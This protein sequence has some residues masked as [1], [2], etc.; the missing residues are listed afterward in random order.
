MLPP[1]FCLVPS[2]TGKT[3]YACGEAFS[4][5]LTLLSYAV[6]YLPYF[7]H[8]FILAG[9]RGMGKST[10]DVRGLFELEQI[11]FQEQ[12]LFCRETQKI[13]IPEGEEL[14]LPTWEGKKHGE[15]TLL[16]HLKTPCRFKAD[17][18]LSTDLSFP[19]LFNLIVRRIRTVWALEGIPVYFEDFPA[20]QSRADAIDT[21]ESS[22][23]WKDWTRYSSRQKASMQLGGLQGSVRYHGNLTAFLPF[24]ALAEKLHIGKQTSF[25]LGQISFEWKAHE[26]DTHS[27]VR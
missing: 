10:D 25:G 20:M 23:F 9:Q 12:P 14:F 13:V 1:P 8:A 27:S 3:Q 17:N 6:E 18:R 4:F 16:L 26:E 5:K 24:L 21:Q 22:L 15:G 2:D 19:Q 7:V 11:F